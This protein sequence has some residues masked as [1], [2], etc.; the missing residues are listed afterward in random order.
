MVKASC[1]P[2]AQNFISTVVAVETQH[3]LAVDGVADFDLPAGLT[4]PSVKE[5]TA[6][7]T[8]STAARAAHHGAV[9]NCDSRCSPTFLSRRDTSPSKKVIQLS[10]P[11]FPSGFGV[12]PL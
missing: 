10:T 12:V 2:P 7:A 8:A 9:P 1:W 6:R 11:L 4:R 5:R 3:R